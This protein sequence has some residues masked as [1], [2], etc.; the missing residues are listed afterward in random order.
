[1][2]KPKRNPSSA[3]VAAF[4]LFSMAC[5]GV[6][7]AGSAQSPPAQQP[8]EPQRNARL[9]IEVTGGEDNVPVENASVYVKFKIDRKLKRDEKVALNV[10]TNHEGIAHIPDPP[11]GTVLIQIVAD[12]WRTYGK[13]F[14]ITDPNQVVKIHLERPPKWY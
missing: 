10:K 14:E 11:V 12:G 5:S 6:F 9:T 4:A 13:S 1:M 8:A 7:V 2:P 3:V